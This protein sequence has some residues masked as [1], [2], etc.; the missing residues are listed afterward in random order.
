MNRRSDHYT[1]LAREKG[2]PARSVF[3]LEEIQDRFRVLSPGDRTLDLGAAPGSW[4]LFVLERANGLVVGVDLEHVP[5]RHERYTFV[6]GD[7]FAADVQAAITG[8]GPFDVVLCDAAPK[9]TGNRIVDTARSFAIAE[10]ALDLGEMCL[11]AGGRCVVKIFQGGE[12][13]GPLDRMRSQYDSAKG[14]KPKASRKGS[15]EVYLVGLGKRAR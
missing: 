2:Y 15:F 7:M 13:K 11:K 1:R 8:H 9:T 3:K 10:R 4:S 5:I 14:F 12:E 6:R